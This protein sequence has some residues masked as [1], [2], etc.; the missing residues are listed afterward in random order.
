MPRLQ[1][2]LD[3]HNP[4]PEWTEAEMV[5]WLQSLPAHHQ[6]MILDKLKEHQANGLR[7]LNIL[8]ELRQL[9]ESRQAATGGLV[10][11][12]MQALEGYAIGSALIDGPRALKNLAHADFSK[13]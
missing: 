3:N 11:M 7:P 5:A 13:D 8:I 6:S 1:E 9:E 4:T 2:L 10:G 12:F